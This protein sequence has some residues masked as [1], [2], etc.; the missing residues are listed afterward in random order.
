MRKIKGRVASQEL[1]GTPVE[2]LSYEATLRHYNAILMEDINSK[3]NLVLES[4]QSF[5]EEYKR[6]IQEFR[7]ETNQRFDVL[8]LA[9]KDNTKQIKE[10]K[11]DV[12]IL[13]TD[14]AGLKT[15]V[16]ELKQ[17]TQSIRTELRQVEGR[18]SQKIDKIA[19]VV[20]NHETRI[21]VLETAHP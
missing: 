6:E 19:S 2:N 10:L 5:R 20:V 1:A 18:L 17:E 3:F 8:E 11:T 14:V 9:V 16:A 13:K 12:G 7:N 15:D 21:T 4:V